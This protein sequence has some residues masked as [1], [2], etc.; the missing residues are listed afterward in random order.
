MAKPTP[1]V[2]S[3]ESQALRD[4][5]GEARAA[6]GGDDDVQRLRAKLGELPA[7][8][9]SAG[10]G[11]AAQSAGLG[12]KAAA[13]AATGV[14]LIA[15]AIAFVQRTPEPAAAPVRA[16]AA[17]PIAAAPESATPTVEMEPARAEPLDALQDAPVPR[18]VIRSK[19]PA[20][21]AQPV[22]APAPTGPKE[23]ELLMSAQDALDASPQ[24]ALGLLDQHAQL[25]PSGN[26][27]L[28]R[29]ALAVEALRKLGR[30]STAQ[31]RARA[32]IM[33]FPSAPSTKRLQRWLEESAR[34]D[35]K[36]E[37]QPLPTR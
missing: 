20:P 19:A 2:G 1:L 33:R 18:K 34:I 36:T 3:S 5:L 29:E 17:A 28:E 4:A 27:A 16:P 35:H 23:L 14:L 8:T 6:L 32:F 30:T 11:G 7:V 26:F 37:T 25:Y 10:A 22:A 31:A 12:V 21:Q 24:R 15:A 9:T 13:L